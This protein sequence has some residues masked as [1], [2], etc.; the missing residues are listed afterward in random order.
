[1]NKILVTG[2]SGFIGTNLIDFYLKRNFEIYNIDIK[3]PRNKKHYKNW[4]KLDILDKNTLISYITKLQP[5][6]IFHMA[7][8]TDLLGKNIDEY[9]ANIEGVENLLEAIKTLKSLKKII[10]F[11]SMLVCE[12][13]YSPKAISDYKPST[14]YG[15]SKMIGEKIVLH[16]FKSSHK[17]LNKKINWIIVRP[18]SI[19]GPWFSAPYKEFFRLIIKSKYFHPGRLDIFRSFGFVL[20]TV[21]QLDK[22]AFS[23]NISAKENFFYLADYN[24]I[25]I[26]VWAN[27]IQKKVG[28]KKIKTAPVFVLY[29]AALVGDFLTRI[30]INFPLT[31]FR[32]K[33]L[34][35]SS[36]YDTAKLKMFCGNLPYNL[37]ESI[38]ITLFWLLSK[39]KYYKE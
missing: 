30:G 27:L 37:D 15:K 31:T 8:R 28:A 17:S 4:I 5:E 24:P 36:T 7:A 25:S 2:G 26:R 39:S 11:S 22:L 3:K 21:Y 19:W 13:G 29:F 6:Y 33:N 16:F 1:M 9:K 12:I 18:T 34:L 14:A 38:E 35:T 10:F 32:L 20:N 23:K